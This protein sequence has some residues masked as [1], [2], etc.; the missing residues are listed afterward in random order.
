MQEIALDEF[1]PKTAVIDDSGQVLTSSPNIDKYLKISGG[2]FQNSIIGMAAKGLKIGLRAA[3]ADAKKHCRRVQHENL[4]L[5]DGEKIQKVMVTVQPMP[6]LG[7]DN[8]L[9]LVVLED[10]GLPIDRDQID[11]AEY[12]SVDDADSMIAHLERELETTRDDL[13]RTLQDLEAGNE[14]L[15][16]ANE[17]LVSMNEELQ[18]ANEELESSKEEIQTALARIA[19]SE[20]DQ[21]NLLHSS[22]IATLFVDDK[23]NIR[24]FTPGVTDIY[25]LIPTD[26]GRPLADI[27]H[28]AVEMPG[29]PPDP[30]NV[31]QWPIEDEVETQAGQWFLRRIQPYTD[32]NGR[33]DGLVLTF[34][35]ITEQKQTAMRLATDNAVTSLLA[36]AESFEEVIPEVLRAI[37]VS[38][39]AEA[40]LLWLVEQAIQG[41]DLCRSRCARPRIRAIC[42]AQ[43][44][45][46]VQRRG[47]TAGPGLATATADLVGR[48][49]EREP[50][51]AS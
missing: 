13:E 50:V 7:E 36:E 48:N 40:C 47:G 25:N 31:Q 32:D 2:P 51:R 23:L 35:D 3:I 9:F 44:R 10:I 4:S 19:Q 5:R 27:T 38:L 34:Y 42:P 37:R 26:M 1:T 41:A 22:R 39:E 30:T 14:E 46:N 12:Q 43:S 49:S 45:S 6:E 8:P 33:N 18:S 29:Y 11:D 21:R 20:S 24:S 28:A 17:E 16:S 15:K